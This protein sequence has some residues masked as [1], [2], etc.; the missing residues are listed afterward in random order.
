MATDGQQ[1]SRRV[2]ALVQALVASGLSAQLSDTVRSINPAT[3][4]AFYPLV[5][6]IAI[7][8]SI[9]RLLAD[10][11]LLKLGFEA[12]RET[13]SLAR[14]IGELAPFAGILLSFATPFTARAGIALA[15][16]RAPE[17]ITFIERHF[18]QKLAEQD[19]ALMND[20]RELARV[21]R[22]P[23]DALERLYAQLKPS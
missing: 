16:A 15:R 23:I 9:D 1:K 22:Q 4:V 21:H 2:S 17:S 6:G 8:R 20:V 11:A 7:A 5:L 18:G 14:C 19:V 3:T 12:S 10:N 13:R